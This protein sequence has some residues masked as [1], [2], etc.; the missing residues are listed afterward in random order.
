MSILACLD[1]GRFDVADLGFDLHPVEMDMAALNCPRCGAKTDV[2]DTRIN[3]QGL[4]RRLRRCSHD[5]CDFRF[6][7]IEMPDPTWVGYDNMR[8]AAIRR[9]RGKRRDKKAE[10]KGM[11]T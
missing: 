1:Q 6:A 2:Y 10:L 11:V 3:K 8:A 9:E 5:P 4:P 7:T